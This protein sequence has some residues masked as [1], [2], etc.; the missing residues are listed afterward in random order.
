M[1]SKLLAFALPLTF[2]LAGNS[3]AQTESEYFNRAA[4]QYV[5]EDLPGTGQILAEGL[6]K[7]PT[8]PKLNSLLEK[9][10]KDQEDQQKKDQQQQQNQDGSDQQENRDQQN[11]DQESG[12]GEEQTDEDGADESEATDEQRGEK[13]QQEEPTEEPS[14]Q[15]SDLSER[16]Q[17]M[18]ELL[19]RLQEMN[20]TP[21]QA[22]QILDAMNSNEL[23]YIQQNRKKATQR[24]QR[25]LPDW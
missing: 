15:E 12:E 8:D 24:P 10:Q 11:E 25:G 9:L 14:S 23:Q 20:L 1:I 16:D 19:Q 2:L 5:N 4:R 21:E 17:S 6:Q 7:Y 3:L 13:S 18:E 22:A